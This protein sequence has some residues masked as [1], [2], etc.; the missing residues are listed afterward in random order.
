MQGRQV[1]Q[2]HTVRAA[3]PWVWAAIGRQDL[4]YGRTLA[5]HNGA[6]RGGLGTVLTGGRHFSGD[7][8]PLQNFRRGRFMGSSTTT[9]G[10]INAL[11]ALPSTRSVAGAALNPNLSS[12]LANGSY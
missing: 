3:D 2:P 6:Y 11:Q 8:G 7:G 4:I 12:M 1:T 9:R 5:G 10:S